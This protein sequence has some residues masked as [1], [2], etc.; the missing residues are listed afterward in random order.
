M[1][2][3]ACSARLAGFKP[4]TRK[5]SLFSY[6]SLWLW[7]LSALIVSLGGFGSAR[8]QEGAT[9]GKII[10]QGTA[11]FSETWAEMQKR[12]AQEQ[13]AIAAGLKPPRS[14]ERVYPRRIPQIPRQPKDQSSLEPSSTV[15]EQAL[16]A[17]VSS[18]VVAPTASFATINLQDEN[19]DFFTS[20]IP[21]DTMGA[22]GP[23]HFLVVINGSV[24][25]YS[26]TGVKSAYRVSLD[27][28]F[29]AGGGHPLN[30]A[31]DP[32]VLFDPASGLWF[33][34][35]LEFGPSCGT[36]CNENNHILLAVS[37]SDDPTTAT[38]NKYV[39]PVGEAGNFTDYDT[40]GVDSNGVYFGM[41]LFSNS[42]SASP[43]KL[44]ATGKASLIAGGPL[45]TV[46]PFPL[47]TD[48]YSSP[49]PTHNLDSI[50][51]TDPAWFVS[52]STSVF[53]DAKY[54]TLTWSIGVPTLSSTGTVS[55]PG[56]G[57]TL[58][59][60]ANGSSPKIDVGDDRLLMAV[61]RNQRL[62]TTRNVGVNSSGG[63]SSANRTGAEWLELNVSSTTA[64][65]VQ[66]GRVYDNASTPRYYYYPSI[67]V[68]AGGDAIMG[69]SGSKGAE[70]VGAY[71]CGRLSADTAGTMGAITLLKSGDAP[72]SVTFG[73]TSNR[74]GDYSYTSID[75]SDDSFWTIQEYAFGTN[76]WG[77]WTARLGFPPPP[78][79]SNLQIN[80]DKTYTTS[81]TVTLTYDTTGLPTQV[82]T[83]TGASWSSWQNL[84]LSPHN[85]NLGGTNGRRDVYVQVRD[86]AG[87]FSNVAWA[88]IILDTAAPKGAVKINGGNTTTNSSTVQLHLAMLDANM[89]GAKMRIKNDA[90]FVSPGDDG[91]WVDFVPFYTGWALSG[92]TGTRKVFVQFKDAAGK[93][94][95]VY[96]AS[97]SVSGG[98]TPWP[99]VATVVISSKALNG[100]SPY[101]TS[102]VITLTYNVDNT[103]IMA[104]Y[105]Y[106]TSWTAWETPA[107][108]GS[109]VTRIITLSGT[110]GPREIYVQLKENATQKLTN[111]QEPDIILDTK[112]PTG[113]IQINN[114]DA[115]VSRSGPT[116]DVTLTIVAKDTASGI[117]KI[118]VNQTGITPAPG[119]YVSFTD[120]VISSYPLDTPAT[121]ARTVYI[122]FKDKAGLVSS[123]KSDSINVTP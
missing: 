40:L 50:G 72:Y 47:I 114:G 31:F 68:N 9:A 28:F 78:T 37:D 43:A 100:G 59:A 82:R 61:I 63:A 104:R 22:V 26:K 55:T 117:D 103:N 69:F 85:I 64:T 52:S 57:A 62:W 113:A 81:P 99:G 2:P 108:A 83:S 75:P 88:H 13:E 48:M 80:L 107:I 27:T 30:G 53:G 14:Q 35:A 19:N 91:L 98:G 109:T 8:A 87:R 10:S 32:R 7:L 17:A 66:S 67:M 3:S 65:L 6:F 41:T 118:A 24:T 110:N 25:A 38:W 112:A 20:Y 70:F 93:P 116:T 96:S 95:A 49:Q 56:Y 89:T 115:S 42:S 4:H 94:S 119:D 120:P 111:P 121:G 54:R 79:I 36:N 15:T 18:T 84:P 71:A 102:K 23:S 12:E 46:T 21:P 29:T 92:G 33:A 1:P 11:P 34:I 73:G 45:G 90:T 58:N 60:P 51:S 39:I 105:F 76:L 5:K 74:W 86:A 77:T 106:G 16:S 97:I 101:S 44:A 123:R 122:W